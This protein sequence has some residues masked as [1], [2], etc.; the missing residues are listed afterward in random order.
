ALESMT[1]LGHAYHRLEADQHAVKRYEEAIAVYTAAEEH[2]HAFQSEI[3]NL[4]QLAVMVADEE[5]QGL[6]LELTVEDEAVRYWRAQYRELLELSALL[7]QKRRDMAVFEV[8]I[9]HRETVFQTF[10]STLNASPSAEAVSEM[11]QKIRVLKARLNRSIDEE[12]LS[13]L[14]TP[15]DETA[16]RRLAAARKTS[17]A[18]GAEIQKLI[19]AGGDTQIADLKSDWRTTDRWLQIAEGDMVWRLSTSLPGRVDDLRRTMRSVTAAFTKLEAR[20][21]QWLEAGPALKTELAA[22]RHRIENARR[23]VDEKIAETDRVRQAI[24]PVLQKKLLAAA[25]QRLE[26]LAGWRSTAELA[27]L[28]ILDARSVNQ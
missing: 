20:Q 23:Q 16:L 21:A 2:L 4:P 8:M 26:R 28:Q 12:R 9:D 10:Q 13:A 6:F 17:A 11:A 24:L 27:R 19:G 15:R 3:Q 7:D 18:I 1:A 14:G 5:R 25:D 22:L